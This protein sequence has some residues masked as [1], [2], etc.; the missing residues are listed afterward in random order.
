VAQ[1]V[2]SR[3]DFVAELYETEETE[4]TENNMRDEGSPTYIEQSVEAD[5]N[6]HWL[7]AMGRYATEYLA[8]PAETVDEQGTSNSTAW[9]RPCQ[10]PQ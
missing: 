10:I 6:D 5:D 1:K 7:Q 2:I 3:V 4:K 9:I 8:R